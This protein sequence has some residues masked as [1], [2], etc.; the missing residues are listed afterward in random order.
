[1][2]AIKVNTFQHRASSFRKIPICSITS[3]DIHI[4]RYRLTPPSSFRFNISS[5]SP[6]KCG[7]RF[8]KFSDSITVYTVGFGQHSLSSFR[9][10]RSVAA[11]SLGRRWII[12]FSPDQYWTGSY[13]FI[14]SLRHHHLHAAK[15][16]LRPQVIRS[17]NAFSPFKALALIWI[18]VGWQRELSSVWLKQRTEL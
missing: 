14:V 8:S 12:P 16:W 10:G 4:S 2:N 15:A 17:S 6:V 9:Q 3:E 13:F 1:M 5:F 18:V 7:L 11:I